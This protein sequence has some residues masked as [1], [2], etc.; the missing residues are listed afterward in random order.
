[1]E[2]GLEGCD[3][4]LIWGIN[5][6]F[7]WWNWG[8]HEKP[9][10][11]YPVCR[12]IFAP[13]NPRYKVGMLLKSTRTCCG[14]V[15]YINP[16]AGNS[17]YTWIHLVN[18]ILRYA[19]GSS[20]YIPCSTYM[21]NAAQQKVVTGGNELLYLKNKTST[22]LCYS[23]SGSSASLASPTTGKTHHLAFW[24]NSFYGLHRLF[25]DILSTLWTAWWTV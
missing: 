4:D 16:T 23:K 8:K 9:Q 5:P 25:N 12:P 21:L 14:G 7:V 13:G 3:C 19:A 10:S 1:M 24:I 2:K 22:I 11:E 15:C 18:D 20:K 6:T 17:V